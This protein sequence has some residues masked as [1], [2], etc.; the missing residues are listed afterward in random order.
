MALEFTL[1]HAT[2]ASAAFDC[3]IVGAYADQTL[4]LLAEHVIPAFNK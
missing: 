4:R 2:P 3:V 1:N